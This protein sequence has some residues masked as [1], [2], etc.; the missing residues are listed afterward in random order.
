MSSYAIAENSAAGTVVGTLASVTDPDAG[1]THTLALEDDGQGRFVIDG[2]APGAATIK[3]STAGGTAGS[4]DYEVVSS[5]VIKVRATDNGATA[6]SFVQ[7]MA[8]SVTNVPEPPVADA[9]SF[10][11]VEESAAGTLVGTVLATSPEDGLD[12]AY[13]VHSSTATA[14]AAIFSIK[15]CSGVLSL[16]QALGTRAAAAT[17]TVQVSATT[18]AGTTTAAVTVNVAERPQPPVLTCPA[19]TIA[20]HS[21]SGTAITLAGGA[22][23]AHT[24]PNA[25]QAITFS[26][27]AGNAHGAFAASSATGA[28]TVAAAVLDYEVQSTYSLTLLGTDAAGLTGSCTL[29]V[30]V[31]DVNDAPTIAAAV[32]S[33]TENAAV[34]ALVGGPITASDPDAGTTLAFSLTG[35]SAAT[36]PFAIGGA[37][38]QITVT[39]ALDYEA[40]PSYALTVT[41]SDGATPALTASA[42]VTVK[43]TDVN[44]VPVCAGT[45]GAQAFTVVENAAE[46]TL[47]GPAALS[48][49]DPDGGAVTYAITSYA[50]AGQRTGT[51]LGHVSVV[52]D[53]GYLLVASPNIDYEQLGGYSYAYVLTVRASDAGGLGCDITVRA[54]RECD[55]GVEWS[56][57]VC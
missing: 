10:S 25:D 54:H 26:I 47:I 12:I 22:S 29:A 40:A 2:T 38:G 1:Q 9:Q 6:L 3:V 17:Y 21:A 32:R 43:V 57:V 45:G 34:G 42:A 41:V 28:V 15:S 27:A 51:A 20:E 35:A 48:A 8:I 19:G 18:T 16:A 4:L 13:A 23:I 46:G 7:S 14:T 44:E 37:S 5:Y 39:A 53:S 56:G 30:T 36:D 55:C 52:A 31:T 11:V 24:D 50:P 49:T 33:V